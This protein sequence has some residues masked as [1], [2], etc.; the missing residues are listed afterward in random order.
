MIMK[1]RKVC[2]TFTYTE[3]KNPCSQKAV[4]SSDPSLFLPDGDIF[5]IEVLCFDCF[6]WEARWKDGTS[7]C[8]GCLGVLG[9][10]AGLPSR[11][12][13]PSGHALLSTTAGG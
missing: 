9:G 5:I 12:V 7:S 6:F 11:L 8:S 10:L 2:F 3:G 1:P 13:R 4:F